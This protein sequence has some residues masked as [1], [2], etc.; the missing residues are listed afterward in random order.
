VAFSN[1]TEH[2]VYQGKSTGK[3]SLTI[4]MEPSEAAKLEDRGVRL[5][6]YEGKAQR[7]F[8][9]KYTVPVV[10][11]DDNPVSGEIPYGSTVRVLWAQGP[12]HPQYGPS[13]FLNRIRVVE[14]SENSSDEIPD[15]F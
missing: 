5:K 7:K 1:I 13:T 2:D 9:T 14:F 10:D 8:S 11:A 4:T 6:D 3:Y 12:D 15:E